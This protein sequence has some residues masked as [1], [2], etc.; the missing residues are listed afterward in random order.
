MET[1][2]ESVKSLL[3]PPRVVELHPDIA[4]ADIAHVF[5]A[6]IAAL[7]LAFAGVQISNYIDNS[8]TAAQGTFSSDTLRRQ[9]TAAEVASTKGCLS[10]ESILLLET[11]LSNST[12]RMTHLQFVTYLDIFCDEPELTSVFTSLHLPIGRRGLQ[13]LRAGRGFINLGFSLSN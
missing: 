4:P 1:A 11:I 6:L 7:K 9:L 12:V 5:L 2:Q 10:L 3:D 8:M 13:L